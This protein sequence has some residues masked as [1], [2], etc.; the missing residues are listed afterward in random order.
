MSTQIIYNLSFFSLWR[1]FFH[2]LRDS[3]G[4]N[5]LRSRIGDALN[6]IGDP[7]PLPI[8]ERLIVVRLTPSTTVT[9]ACF[10]K[11]PYHNIKPLPK[12]RRKPSLPSSP[13]LLETRLTVRL[14][15]RPTSTRL[16]TRRDLDAQGSLQHSW[17]RQFDTSIHTIVQQMC[18]PFLFCLL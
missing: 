4:E 3:A 18:L 5:L 15:L 10:S 16:V 8:A 12:H 7:P 11:T 14:D 13:P 17:F 9:P 1:G 6:G 2:S